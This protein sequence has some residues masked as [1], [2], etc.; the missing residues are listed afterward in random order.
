MKLS[1]LSISSLKSLLAQ[2]SEMQQARC[3]STTL[4][5]KSTND[6]LDRVADMPPDHPEAALIAQASDPQ[7][8]EHEL[9]KR[10][11]QYVQIF[12]EVLD[13]VQDGK[14]LTDAQRWYMSEFIALQIL[15]T[16]EARR[17]NIEVQKG[18]IE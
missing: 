7:M 16:P 13:A 15:R 8:I 2:Q 12:D 18:L 11:S 1:T 4:I 9:G 6:F 5:H 17:T 3:V 14:R 10:E